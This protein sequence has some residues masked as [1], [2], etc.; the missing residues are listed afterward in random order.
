MII[1]RPGEERTLDPELRTLLE[2]V[3][4]ALTTAGDKMRVGLSG[5]G[6]I[7]P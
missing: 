3:W 4:G 6:P 7:A 1:R 5:A 2:L